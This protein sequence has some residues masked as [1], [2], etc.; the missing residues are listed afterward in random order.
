MAQLI[1][2]D[3]Q[4]DFEKKVLTQ[5]TPIVVQFYADWC[6][7]CKKLM[8]HVEQKAKDKEACFKVAKINVDKNKE[9]AGSHQVKGIPA[10]YLYDKS[11]IIDQ[12]TGLNVQKMDDYLKKSSV[13]LTFVGQSV[14]L[15][16]QQED[17]GNDQINV[18]LNAGQIV[19]DDSKPK[20][21]VTI[22]LL[23]GQQKTVEIN[24]SDKVQSLF[25]YVKIISGISSF[26][27]LA[28]FPP[29]PLQNMDATIEDED[30]EDSRVTQ[31]Q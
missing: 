6:G 8:A 20:T 7:P 25:N 21:N 9:L 2:I 3:G 16:G 23:D 15:G 5:K 26:K 4:Q 1:E 22:R 12:F 18:N 31:S 28:G 29:K 27:L 13:K 30:L 24:T 19:V 17:I 10:V 14:S 11:K